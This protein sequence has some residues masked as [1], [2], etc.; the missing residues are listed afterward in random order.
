MFVTVGIMI[1]ITIGFA[2]SVVSYISGRQASRDEKLATNSAN[3]KKIV[4]SYVNTCA[5][6]EFLNAL[7]LLGKQG[8]VIYKNQGGNYEIQLSDMNVKYIADSST[9]INILYAIT[10]PTTINIVDYFNPDYP[11]PWVCFPYLDVSGGKSKNMNDACDFDEGKKSFESID[12][13]SSVLVPLK[14]NDGTNSIQETLET[15]LNNNISKCLDFEPL[16]KQGL[17]VIPGT[18]Q[19]SINILPDSVVLTIN[20]PTTIIRPRTNEEFHINT[21]TLNQGIRIG[22]VYGIIFL[23]TLW[24]SQD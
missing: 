13:G 9:G 24:I 6:R 3:T 12:F 5:E 4:E 17:K 1:L 10:L 18:V 19:T 16:E 14:R 15:Y 8:G 22:R 7:R 11:Y 23:I 20:M 2:F 21:Y